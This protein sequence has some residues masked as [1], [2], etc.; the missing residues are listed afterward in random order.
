MTEEEKIL[1]AELLIK[2]LRQDTDWTTNDDKVVEN[3]NNC[4]CEISDWN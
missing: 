4:A 3:I 1:L 2:W